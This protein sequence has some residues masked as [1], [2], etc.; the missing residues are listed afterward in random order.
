MRDLANSR[1]RYCSDE[2]GPIYVA[3]DRIVSR[4][5]FSSSKA[6]ELAL[7]RCTVGKLMLCAAALDRV[8]DASEVNH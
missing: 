1:C 5:A 6:D 3:L 2:A 7:L 8:A 4:Y